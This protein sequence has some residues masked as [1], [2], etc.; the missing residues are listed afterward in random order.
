MKPAIYPIKSFFFSDAVSYKTSCCG[1]F[2]F[3]ISSKFFY[4]FPLIGGRAYIRRC[5]HVQF[6]NREKVNIANYW[7][8]NQ[9][10]DVA[11]NIINIIY[12]YTGKKVLLLP[13]DSMT[14][15]P[16][17]FDGIGMDWICILMAI[18]EQYNCLL[19]D[20]LYENKTIN[21]FISIILTVS[22]N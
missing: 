19:P 10:Y 8:N 3:L 1:I 14:V 7:N 18:E 4:D 5:L 16:I 9:H 20:D 21:D 13:D 17:L 11:K 12:E 2:S 22:Q 6:R 15:F